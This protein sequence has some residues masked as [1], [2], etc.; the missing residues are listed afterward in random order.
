MFLVAGFFAWMGIKIL[1]DPSS[2]AVLGW[3]CLAVAAFKTMLWSWVAVGF[4]R[5]PKE[6]MAAGRWE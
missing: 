6:M 3:I 4:I 5:H 1:T 2:P